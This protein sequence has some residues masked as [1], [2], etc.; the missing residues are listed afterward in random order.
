MSTIERFDPIEYYAQGGSGTGQMEVKAD[1][2]WVRYEDCLAALRASDQRADRLEKALR[3]ILECDCKDTQE[4]ARAALAS[5]SGGEKSG[6][7][8]SEMLDW[9]F[10]LV[11]ANGVDALLELAWH[12]AP[13]CFVLDRAAITSAMEDRA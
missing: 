7:S 1:G 3:A 13:K 12:D 11:N 4:E 6:P 9:V 2:D 5:P 10:Q 8:D